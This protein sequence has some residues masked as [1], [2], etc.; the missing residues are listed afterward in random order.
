MGKHYYAA[1]HYYGIEFCN[2]YR[3][4]FRFSRCA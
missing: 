1:Q 4:L 3:T 2:D